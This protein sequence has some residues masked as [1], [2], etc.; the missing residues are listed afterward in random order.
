MLLR[1]PLVF[2][3]VQQASKNNS[4]IGCALALGL[5]DAGM[6]LKQPGTIQRNASPDCY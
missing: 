6:T 5:A 1:K 3:R 4:R 2:N